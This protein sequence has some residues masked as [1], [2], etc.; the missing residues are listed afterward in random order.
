MVFAEMK[1][2]KMI[3]VRKF[4]LQAEHAPLVRIFGSLEGI[5]V[6]TVICFQRW[7]LT[8][9]LYDFTIEYMQIQPDEDYVI[10]SFILKE[11]CGGQSS[12]LSSVQ[13]QVGETR[14]TI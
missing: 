13:F 9:L 6:Y 10:A 11:V 12:T 2:R 1:F 5:P 14:D 4:R 8:L 7:A 3:L